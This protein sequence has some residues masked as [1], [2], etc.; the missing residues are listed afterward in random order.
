[1]AFL[2]NKA[3][4]RAI[5]LT[6]KLQILCETWIVRPF[7]GFFVI[8]LLSSVL[9]FRCAAAD[10][11]EMFGIVPTIL[12]PEVAK[13]LGLT[14]LQEDR[15]EA[16]MESRRNEALDLASQIRNLPPGER[17]SKM[18]DLVRD[19][20]RQCAA[21]L[22]LQQRS[23]MERLRVSAQGLTSL[24]DP[25]IAQTLELSGGQS[26]Q[27]QSILGARSQLTRELGGQ[28]LADAEI[29]RRLRKL[30]TQSQWSTWQAV[31]GQSAKRP[32][33]SATDPNA[34]PT[35][36]SDN[37]NA[38]SD[39]EASVLEPT[40]V[41]Q[42]EIE[43]VP[44]DSAS[45]SSAKETDDE[46]GLKKKEFPN[47]D[48]VIAR[49]MEA[50]LTLNFKATPWEQVLQ[51][52]A[53]EAE[54]S[55][56]ADVYPPGTFTYRDPYRTYTIGES[57]DLMNG[58]LLS[59]GYRL[60]RRQRSLMVIDLG[61]GE[62][63]EIVR[64]LIRELAQL[65]PPE[66]LDQ[67]GEYDL[68]KC[69]FVLSRLSPEEAQKEIQLLIGPEGS[70]VPLT[71]AGQILVT[72]TAGKLKLIREMLSRVE[73]PQNARGS[74]IVT[75]PLKY[76]TAE[77]LLSVARPLL[78]LKEESNQS[79]DLNLSTDAFGNTLYATG[80]TDKLQKLS[81]FV[82]LMDVKPDSSGPASVTVEQPTLRTHPILSSDPETALNV[83]QT[84][85]AGS[86]NVRIALEPKT[87]SIVASGVQADH[88]LIVE[89]LKEL[90]GQNSSF[91]VIPLVRIDTQAAV[92]TLEKFFGKTSGKEGDSTTGPI[93]FGDVASRTIMIKGS[94]QQ[95]EQVKDLISKLEEAG[96]QSDFLGK[97][98]RV[99]PMSGK[100]AD[101]AL[102][103]IQ[104]LW[105]AKKKKNR[106][107]IRLPAAES[108]KSD[109][110]VPPN[111]QQDTIEPSALNRKHEQS[112]NRSFRFIATVIESDN[113]TSIAEQKDSAD[114]NLPDN[115]KVDDEA[116]ANLGS[117]IVVFRGPN[118]L[119]V[120]SEDPDALEEFEQLA[121]MVTEQMNLGGTEP[122]VFYLKFVSAKGAAELL[123]SI[124]AGESASSS[125]GGGGG[126]LGS[127]LGE[128]G[129]GLVGSL[130][131]GGGGA[132]MSNSI[133]GGM[134]SGEV[135][136]TA[137]P[138]LNCLV[139]RANT[140][141][142]DLIADLLETIDQEDSPIKIE[143][144][145]KVRLIPVVNNKVEEIAAVVKQVFADRI[146]APPN[147]GGQQRQPS[148]QE[149]IEALRGGGGRGGRGGG[150]TSELKQATMTIGTDP[151]NNTL[152]VSSSQ[153][154]YDEVEALVRMLDQAALEKEE[155]V[156]VIQLD[157]SVNA[158]VL[159]NALR[160][161]FG[162]QA[163]STTVA[164]ASTANP[165]AVKSNTPPAGG[166]FDPA[167]AAQRAEFF[168]QFQGGGRGGAPSG[169]GGGASG[170]TGGGRGG[171]NR[172][173]R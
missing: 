107:Q 1:M 9:A 51:W 147:A 35:L 70:I 67:R 110:N 167:G 18:R 65:V 114:S 83:L 54:L 143:T 76:V 131:G 157:G 151:K 116:T 104:Y 12:Q 137:D 23:Q 141:D 20:E 19:F 84:L 113:E 14:A 81:D 98:V 66:E 59:K 69:L 127:V 80:S 4:L 148:P 32:S 52:I 97:T 2:V 77:E 63:P 31:A 50:P 122:T 79:E 95:V 25:D 45:T 138:R 90:A 7:I 74:K 166:G 40:M 75:I 108:E 130:L 159:Q 139:V 85:L 15:I 106:I 163:K 124:L 142:L 160:A 17:P 149:F 34:D 165:S 135:S 144:S 71:S 156:E 119:I 102:E 78:G 47:S 100:S 49:N 150:G 28:E 168:R 86:S 8:W 146:A 21:V 123:K 101:R 140:S 82:A 30:L 118:G 112:R 44:P 87:N 99:L 36:E 58:V 132:S 29:Q 3:N 115:N 172:G 136:M 129:G 134:A 93:F 117:D 125:G 33:G 103:Q 64:G 154:L 41:P 89:T 111:R 162:S 62:S 96:P 161:T 39:P 153:S 169:F 155:K 128:M 57:L 55:V 5:L 72:E 171:G 38:A 92:L 120:T 46:S 170:G 68:V 53:N 91:N 164:N 152:I 48:Q 6:F 121:R 24:A 27:I 173:G 94:P 145:G 126:I 37:N 10:D 42:I 11:P 105:E 61:N 56:Q 73:N 158:T 60:V 16:L 133:S 109:K 43:N 88:K 22:T 26:E 13:Q